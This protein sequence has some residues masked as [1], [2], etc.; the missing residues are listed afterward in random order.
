MIDAAFGHWL[1]GFTDGEGHFAL[2]ARQR[3]GA[4]T[5]LVTAA[6]IIALREDDKKILDDI[7]RR[8]GVGTVRRRLQNRGT[9]KGYCRQ[10]FYCCSNPRDLFNV[11]VP[12]F[13]RHR[14]RAKKSR[15]FAIWVDGVARIVEV[16]DRPG[17]GNGHGRWRQADYKYVARQE[18]R[19]RAGRKMKVA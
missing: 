8:L 1:A 5:W 18:T 11:V 3:P 10:A 14:L 13:R 12:V 7:R 15:D 9:G 16:R 2:Y 4:K 19:L 6:F 17:P